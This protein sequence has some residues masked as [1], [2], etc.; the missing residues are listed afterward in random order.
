MSPAY[1]PLA[2]FDAVVK[3]YGRLTTLDGADLQLRRDEWLALPG[4][5]G[6]GKTTAIGLLPGLIRA[7]AGGVTWFGQ[8]P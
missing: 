5:N 6:A 2:R 8:G 3:R 4:P 7:G 1:H